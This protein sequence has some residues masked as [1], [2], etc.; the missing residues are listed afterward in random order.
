VCGIKHLDLSKNSAW[1]FG[2]SKVNTVCLNDPMSSRH[3]AKLEILQERHY[4]FVDLN[5]RNGSLVNGQRVTQPVLLKHGD[6]ISIGNTIL[7]FQHRVVTS[8]GMPFPNP[9]KQ[10]LMLQ[11]SAVQGKIWQEILLAQKV[12]VVWEA[13]SSELKKRIALNA[14]SNTLPRVLL[15]DQKAYRVKLYD[16]CNWCRQTHPHLKV[17]LTDSLRQHIPD[18]ERYAAIQQGCLNLFPALPKSDLV[19]NA[20]H[21][22]TQMNEVL[23]AMD[24]PSIQPNQILPTLKGLED[25]MK[26]GASF[27]PLIDD[28][29]DSEHDIPTALSAHGPGQN[30][31]D[32]KRA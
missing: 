11:M 29:L 17:F 1:T 20:V 8:Y 9:S 26:Q 25:L 14:T 18:R 12:S 21:I 31:L 28:E 27:V 2:R 22:S 23:Q 32:K 15:L 24:S 4:Y 7:L 6:Y 19:I 5:S 3:H 30:R 16:F 13:S 10:V